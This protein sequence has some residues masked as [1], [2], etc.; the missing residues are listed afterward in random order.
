MSNPVGRK[1]FTL[2]ELLVVVAIIAILAALLLPALRE[3]RE[4]A[5]STTCLNNLKQI[6]LAYQMYQ[7]DHNGI[8]PTVV[9]PSVV[10]SQY[11]GAAMLGRYY[12]NNKGVLRC[13]TDK[14]LDDLSY[15]VNEY[16]VYGLAVREVKRPGNIVLLRENQWPG[17]V[18]V[19]TNWPY[20]LGW[21]PDVYPGQLAHR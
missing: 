6:G 4:S 15:Y 2:I 19:A 20:G 8:F 17:A 1:A 12:A 18:Y 7:D 13:P 3:A 10:G 11:N 14:T 16:L 9:N 5:K 21:W